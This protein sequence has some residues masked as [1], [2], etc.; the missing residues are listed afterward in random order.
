[1]IITSAIAGVSAAIALHLTLMIPIAAAA[2]G[3]LAWAVLILNLDRLLIISMRFRGSKWR[4]FMVVV[5]RLCMALLVGTVVATPLL[6]QVFRA[7][8]QGELPVVHSQN[9]AVARGVIVQRFGDV[10]QLAD[11]VLKLQAVAAG[12]QS[13]L[14]RENP[15]VVAAREV[16]VQAQRSYDSAIS[17]AQCELNGT[18]GT[19]RAGIGAEYLEKKAIADNAKSTLDAASK[20]YEAAISAAQGKAASSAGS[21]ILAAKTELSRIVPILDDRRIERDN[22][23]S[24]AASDEYHNEGILAQLQALDRLSDEDSLFRTVQ[25]LLLCLI[26]LIELLP[27]LV[28][29]LS[30][31]GSL[32]LYDQLLERE[33][34]FSRRR[35]EAR[36]DV[37][38]E[39]END[40]RQRQVELGR[41]A[42]RV[43]VEAQ[44]KVVQSAV[45]AW[46]AVATTKEHEELARWYR[47]L[48]DSNIAD[49][50]ATGR[51]AHSS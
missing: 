32:T 33:E 20:R 45:Q 23:L 15:D 27:M 26:L 37:E 13:A 4:N 8:I 44:A 31:I 3:G 29:V 46:Q 43:L 35:S 25:I 47:D 6:L 40:L 17:D 2:V 10:E 34:E 38:L 19:H 18:C 5:P 51:A 48:A 7:E 16:V 41:E 50:S 28:K 22:A 49:L 42:N 21:E 36:M 1:M 9:L 39:I 12:D 24:Q 14:V 30:G 11:R